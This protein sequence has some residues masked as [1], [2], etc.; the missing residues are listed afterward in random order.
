MPTL[1]LDDIL[2][3]LVATIGERRLVDPELDEICRDFE[4]L[5]MDYN[6][7]VQSE[8]NE[9]LRQKAAIRESLEG[10]E[11]EIRKKIG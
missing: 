10:L 8:R 5:A 9:D 2:T 6:S 1:T 4:A 3:D 11:Q 7:L